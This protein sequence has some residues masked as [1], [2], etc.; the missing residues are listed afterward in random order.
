MSN[1]AV[2]IASGWVWSFPAQI[3]R[4]IDGDSAYVHIA[5]TAREYRQV[6]TGT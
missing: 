2:V 5:R 6:K 1:A 4:W 3:D